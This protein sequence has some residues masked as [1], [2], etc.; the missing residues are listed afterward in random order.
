MK[1]AFAC[2]Q[3]RIA[4]VFDVARQVRVVDTAPDAAAGG[5]LVALPEGAARR[6]TRLAELSVDTLVC[7]AISRPVEELVRSH[8]VRIIAF[9]AGATDALI[10]AW[11]AGRLHEAAYAMP[12]CCGRRGGERRMR[13]R[14]CGAGRG[15][16]GSMREA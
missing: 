8:G 16:P 3:E 1:A 4:P 9:V 15:R 10:Q 7:G 11:R 2:W 13:R 6:A 5:T 14:R 12:G